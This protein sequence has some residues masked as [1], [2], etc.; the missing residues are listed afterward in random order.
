MIIA[1]LAIH[2]AG[3]AYVPL[4]PNDPFQRLL[5]IADEIK[6]PV[7]LSQQR[8]AESFPGH[9][10]KVICLDSE[11]ASIEQESRENPPTR[12]T[13]D[14]LAYVV[15]SSSSAG[16]PKGVEI[17]HRS[18]TNFVCWAA[19]AYELTPS[20]RV[21]QFASIS[22]DTAVEE[23]FP[24]LASGAQ[25]VLHSDSMSNP[26]TGLLQRCHDWQVSVLDLPTAYWH[27]LVEEISPAPPTTLD[28]LRLVIASGEQASA[29]DLTR[30]RDVTRDQVRLVNT[31]GATEATVVATL[32]DSHTPS[33]KDQSS[34]E[35]SI[36][37]PVAN[38]QVYILDEHLN[39]VPV[40]VPGEIYIG[41]AGLARGYFKS[42][43]LTARQ[44]VAHPF[45]QDTQARLYKTGDWARYRPD[46]NIELVGRFDDR[47][48]IAGFRVEP[49]E[50]ETTLRQHRSV[51]DAVVLGRDDVSGRR[52]L[53]AY[54]AACK[55]AVPT[56]SELTGFLRALLPHYM[57]PSSFIFMKH[58]SMSPDGTIDRRA[59][60]G[61]DQEGIESKDGFVAPRTANEKII[62]SIWTEI[63]NLKQI[64]VYDDFFELTN[65]STLAID[66]ID[67]VRK[68]FAAD[69][70]VRTLFEVPTVAGMAAAVVQRQNHWLIEH[71]NV[72]LTKQ[73]PV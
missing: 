17:T 7:I 23:I 34:V 26:L 30:W 22:S 51:R 60:V 2:K 48:K 15:Y 42:P 20:D 27:E 19:S 39:P 73:T 32:W 44:F 13:A 31:Y 56:V 8:L 59:C 16:R 40:G 6:F 58:P 33:K 47:I 63:L 18:L 67:R 70:S 1:L 9:M 29:I 61:L 38:T 25:L 5:V 3:G 71:S 41:G 53:V 11:W 49:G 66:L 68:A 14:D 35:I 62:A 21:L 52:R 4:D 65:Q 24:C 45:S 36:G 64:S 12:A 54:V 69:L 55:G 57:V 46:G 72:Q 28:N 50:I 43:E 37:R 10:A